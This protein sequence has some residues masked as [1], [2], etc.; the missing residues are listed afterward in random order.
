MTYFQRTA[1]CVFIIKILLITNLYAHDEKLM[2]GGRPDGHAPIGVMGD[3]MHKKGEYMMSY[4][5]MTMNMGGLLDGSDDI[6]ETSAL[7]YTRGDGTTHRIIPDSM[8]MQMHMLGFMY[9]YNDTITLMGM[10]NYNEKDMTNNTYNMM[11]TTKV[12]KFSAH[13]EGFGDSSIST[14][15]KTFK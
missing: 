1:F 12:G 7:N 11:G 14:L 4:R 5:Y 10:I 15:I 9:G 3:H 13:T 8:D 2:P 6:S